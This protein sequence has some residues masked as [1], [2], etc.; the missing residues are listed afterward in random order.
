M[1]TGPQSTLD[2]GSQE[3][4][5]RILIQ[6]D[7]KG[8]STGYCL[9]GEATKTNKATFE[10]KALSCS[11]YDDYSQQA[12]TFKRSV[13]NDQDQ[14]VFLRRPLVDNKQVVGYQYNLT[15]DGEVHATSLGN[16]SDIGYLSFH[17][18]VGGEK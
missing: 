10:F 17:H 14:L 11:D 9:A 1:G 2:D 18:V 7:D 3:A 15:D 6:S 8:A 13:S 4:Y 12:R 5:G 16:R